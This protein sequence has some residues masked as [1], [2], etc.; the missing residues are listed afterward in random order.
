M[1]RIRRVGDLT[2]ARI[3]RTNPPSR[4]FARPAQWAR[5]DRQAATLL[6]MTVQQRLVTTEQLLDSW[7]AVLASPRRG[8][9]DQ[10]IRDVCDGAQALAELDFAALCRAGGLPEPTRQAVRVG[11]RG[12]VYLDVW[13][14]EYGVHVEIHGAQHGWGLA[15]VKDSCAPI[16]SPSRRASPCRS[17]SSGCGCG[18]R[19]SWIRSRRRWSR[20][21]GNVA[22]TAEREPEALRQRQ[23]LHNQTRPATIDCRTRHGEGGR[24]LVVCLHV[25]S[26]CA[27]NAGWLAR[28]RG[29][30]PR[31]P[32]VACVIR[33]QDVRR[34]FGDVVALDGLSWR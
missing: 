10:V 17:P 6:A 24:G 16:G 25:Q 7:G 32:T 4:W 26:S 27:A 21:G 34:A 31:S 11:P 13:F 15:V 8:V 20:A 14:E 28:P 22:S 3:P 23:R 1:R 33:F 12:V 2:G 9:I 29:W 30:R 5:T 19:P 18:P